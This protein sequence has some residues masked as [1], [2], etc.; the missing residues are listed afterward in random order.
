M[1]GYPWSEDLLPRRSDPLSM[2]CHAW[3]AL[4]I[5]KRVAT[6]LVEPY[7]YAALNEVFGRKSGEGHLLR[8]EDRGHD[9]LVEG[10]PLAARAMSFE[11]VMEALLFG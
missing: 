10:E 3:S 11:E 9:L 2:T 1:R 6:P 5:T 7:G 8:R 4:A